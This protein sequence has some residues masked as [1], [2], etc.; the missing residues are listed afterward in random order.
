MNLLSS[1][2]LKLVHTHLHTRTFFKIP[3]NCRELTLQVFKRRTLLILYCC[4]GGHILHVAA[5][6]LI[7]HQ[8]IILPIDLQCVV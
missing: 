3:D 5:H 2:Y 6:W 8:L 4:I 7:T 1:R